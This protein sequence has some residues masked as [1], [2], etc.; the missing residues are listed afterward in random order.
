MQALLGRLQPQA[1][2]RWERYRAGDQVETHQHKYNTAPKPQCPQQQT[3]SEKHKVPFPLAGQQV[4]W[5]K[6]QVKVLLALLQPH[7]AIASCD[8]HTQVQRGQVLPYR[9]YL[10]D[11]SPLAAADTSDDTIEAG[12]S[13]MRVDHSCHMQQQMY[14]TGMQI[15]PE[16]LLRAD[17]NNAVRPVPSLLDSTQPVGSAEK[18]EI[19]ALNAWQEMLHA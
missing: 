4:C 19:L 11:H 18:L 6:V 10:A 8:W 13:P 7:H 5:V 14:P 3:C 2:L 16:C 17:T 9:P 1:G 12:R 15:T